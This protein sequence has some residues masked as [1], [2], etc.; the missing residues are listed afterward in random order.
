MPPVFAQMGRDAVRAA[1]SQ[2]T[3]ATSQVR[4]GQAR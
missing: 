2:I 1:A 4:H 3:A